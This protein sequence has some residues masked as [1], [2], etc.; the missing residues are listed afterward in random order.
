MKTYIAWFKIFYKRC[1]A[2]L[3]IGNSFLLLSIAFK[4]YGVPLKYLPL[5]VIGIIVGIIVIG[6][7]DIF[8]F[9]VYETENRLEHEQSPVFMEILTRVRRIR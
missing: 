3:N 4:T 9:K 1:N 2:Y 8:V 5:G 7:M 6:F